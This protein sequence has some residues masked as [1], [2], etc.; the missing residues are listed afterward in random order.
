[1][2]LF[3]NTSKPGAPY[4]LAGILTL[5]SFLHCYELPSNPEIAF[6]KGKNEKNIECVGLLDSED[7]YSLN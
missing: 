5:W 3:E 7:E 4:L 2:S 6:A 1:M